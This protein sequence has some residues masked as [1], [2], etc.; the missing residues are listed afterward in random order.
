MKLKKITGGALL[1]VSMLFL[2]SGTASMF[3]IGEEEMPDLIKKL[4]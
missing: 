2:N 4:R 3:T 1:L